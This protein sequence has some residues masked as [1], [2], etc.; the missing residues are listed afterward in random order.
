MT[1]PLLLMRVPYSATNTTLITIMTFNTTITPIT[2]N[3]TNTY[4]A[5]NCNVTILHDATST[6]PITRADNDTTHPDKKEKENDNE[7]KQTTKN[8][9]G[10]GLSSTM[11]SLSESKP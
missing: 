6:R 1:T 10:F 9:R 7:R 5:F 2:T 11:K 3:S 8:S 4:I